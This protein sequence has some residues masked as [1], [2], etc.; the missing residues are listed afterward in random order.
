MSMDAGDALTQSIKVV[1]DGTEHTIKIVGTTTEY[2]E[3]TIAFIM[4]LL[5]KNQDKPSIG[6]TNLVKM[7]QSGQP[8][9]TITLK[10]DDLPRFA[11][12][13][14]QYG[15]PFT[16]VKDTAKNSNQLDVLV[17]E[18]D[19]E[20]INR[21]FDILNQEQITVEPEDAKKKSIPLTPES[22]EPKNKLP[23]NKAVDFSKLKEEKPSVIAKINQAKKELQ[24]QAKNK[25]KSQSKSKSTA[26]RS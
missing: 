16:P 6:K 10:Q 11:D 26:E 7:L 17:R 24:K 23:E 9:K 5:Q 18:N 21:I 25:G 22:Q 2:I 3:K 8:L 12:L 13:A 1:L 4:A 15:L 20:T 14:K 19:A